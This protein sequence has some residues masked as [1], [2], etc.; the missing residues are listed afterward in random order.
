[1]TITEITN[2]RKAGRLAEAM[3]AAE[4][5]FARN[6][7]K[8]TAGA[9]FW[10]LYEQ[11]KHQSGEDAVATFERMKTLYHDYCPEDDFIQKSVASAQRRILPHYDEVKKAA[12]NAKNGADAIS[13]CKEVSNLYNNGELDTQLY[14]DFGWL[15]YYALKQTDL[16]DAHNRKNLLNQYLKLELPR[17]SILHSLILGEAVKVE[18]NTPLLF[19]IR[20]FVRLWGLENLR[21]EDW[22][23]FHTTDGKTL[24]STVERLISVYAKELETD[25][26][27]SPEEFNELVDK[28]LVKYPKNQNMPSYKAKVLISQGRKSEAMAYY[29]DLILRSPLKYNY[30]SKTAE[31][32]DDTDTKIG[33][34]CK[35]LS[36]GADDEFLGNVRLHLST[37]LIQKGLRSNAK[38]ELEKYRLTYQN[39]GWNLKSEFWHIY[40]QLHSTEPADSNNAL[41]AEFEAKA[42]EFIYSSFPTLLAVKVGESQFD[43]RIHPGR[44]IMTWHLR[45]AESDLKL[46]KPAK[47]GLNR[48]TANG[49]AFDVKI[50]NKEIVWIKEHVGVI[51]EPWLKEQSGEVHMRIDRKGRRYAII[52]GTYV[53]ERLL[54]GVS[55]GQQ[56]KVLSI[57]EE[58][59]RWRAVSVLN[60]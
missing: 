3:E 42:Y 7:N 32:V 57:R 34:L 28:A 52:A 48:L 21:D 13:A 23:Q 1:M 24:P 9:L 19:R 45:T 4:A 49:V 44:K 22:E 59:G 12:E 60:S 54:K 43:D 29:K 15:T 31:L 51:S 37:L 8:Y 55:E 2:L 16:K 27:E 33:L 14:E 6:A 50:Y 17:P 47:F 41:Y 36:C 35:A 26:V 53:G 18:K 38:Y 10:C 46:R 5:E 25:R 58:D 20:D 30:W 40:N 39:K 11:F 56:I